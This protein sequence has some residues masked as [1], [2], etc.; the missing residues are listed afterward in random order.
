VGCLL[1]E[2]DLDLVFKWEKR[3]GALASYES[4]GIAPGG[5]GYV[6]LLQ[7]YAEQSPVDEVLATVLRV[8]EQAEQFP[9]KNYEVPVP[10]T[11]TKAPSVVESP[12]LADA[13]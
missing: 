3:L 13:G 7:S 12:V 10:T 4:N 6:Y 2:H 11:Q 9:D 5:I 1:V 8:I